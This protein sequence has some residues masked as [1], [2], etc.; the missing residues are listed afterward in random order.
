MIHGL[1]LAVFDGGGFGRRFFLSRLVKTFTRGLLSFTA[2]IFPFM[3]ISTC[4]LPHHSSAVDCKAWSLEPAAVVVGK[5][6]KAL[7]K[8][9]GSCEGFYSI[10]LPFEFT[11]FV[12][13]FVFRQIK[14]GRSIYED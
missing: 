5:R 14:K 2:I 12:F 13:S 9:G 1:Q 6:Y 10:G 4:H 3:A 7:A 11:A 8:R